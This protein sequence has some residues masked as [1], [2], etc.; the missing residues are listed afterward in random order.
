MLALTVLSTDFVSF[1]EG[2][3]FPE[4]GPVVYQ[5]H[6]VVVVHAANIYISCVF[7]GM[8]FLAYLSQG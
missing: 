6:L 2:F 3:Q 1:E 8:K 5:S 4:G 7:D